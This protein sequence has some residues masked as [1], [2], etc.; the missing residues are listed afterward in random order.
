MHF[1]LTYQG[2]LK[3]NGNA[4]QKHELRKFFHKQ[5][6]RLWVI[7]PYLS[8]WVTFDDDAQPVKMMSVI[9][10]KNSYLPYYSF[11]PLITKELRVQCALEVKF[12][13]PTSQ[14]G[15]ESDMDNLLKTLLDGL[16]QPD[17]INQL[18]SYSQPEADEKPFYTLLSDD[19][20]ITK[21]TST[22]GELLQPI[23]GN[24]EIGE[25]DFRVIIDVFLRPHIPNSDNI[26]FFSNE[27]EVWD[28][29]FS[30]PENLNNLTDDQLK[31]TST[32]M[33]YRIMALHEAVSKSRLWGIQSLKADHDPILEL[34]QM[35][36][37]Y[38][39]IWRQSMR[40]KTLALR[41][42]LLNRV[43]RD[44]ARPPWTRSTAI[45]EGMLSGP[46]PLA[47]AADILQRLISMGP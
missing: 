37:N 4:S 40:G 21:I 29:K 30:V 14:S 18:G 35:D 1:T 23:L 41:D 12:F 25:K 7:D 24:P 20:L 36:N 13:R 8:E 17:S 19:R 43:F 10:A 9:E 38:D 32:Q 46:N 15:Q 28:Y 27:R 39:N 16:Q 44:Q 6:K 47:D 42:E 26:I 45:D 34:G 3:T 31:A 5:L 22:T 2:K 11:I 33:I